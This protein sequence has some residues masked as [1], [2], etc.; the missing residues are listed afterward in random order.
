MGD[1]FY[2]SLFFPREETNR[3]AHKGAAVLF[4]L[5]QQP[6]VKCRSGTTTAKGKGS[7][8]HEEE[9]TR[10][11]LRDGVPAS[12]TKARGTGRI[13]VHTRIDRGEFDVTLECQG[14][15]TQSAPIQSLSL[16]HRADIPRNVVTAA[17]QMPVGSRATSTRRDGGSICRT[18]ALHRATGNGPAGHGVWPCRKS[19]AC[20]V[21]CIRPRAD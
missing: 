15:T 11:R 7:E 13:L 3:R 2:A 1:S 21:R 14:Q 9:E 20:E 19:R 5:R 17:L 10:G 4:W 6:A 12:A 16:S 18:Q 8:S